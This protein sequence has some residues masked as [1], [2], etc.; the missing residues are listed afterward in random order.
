MATLAGIT[1]ALATVEVTGSGSSWTTSGEFVAGL[2]GTGML[3]IA[4][5]GNVSSARGGI[6]TYSGSNGSVIVAGAGSTWTN[7][8]YLTVGNSGAGTLEIMQGGMVSASGQVYLGQYLGSAGTINIG[9]ATGAPVAAGTLNAPIVQFGAGSATLNFNHTDTNYAFAA[10][11]AS[12][13][14][15]SHRINQIAGTNASHG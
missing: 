2:S 5:G 12:A 1:A 7:S 6:G 10:G 9:A 15:G 8:G 13:G 3:T 4:A 11:L 14:A